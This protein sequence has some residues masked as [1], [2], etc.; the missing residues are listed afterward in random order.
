MIFILESNRYLKKYIKASLICKYLPRFLIT[1]LILT[2][3]FLFP[4]FSVI[5]N[6]LGAISGIIMQF[7]LPIVSYQIYF[8]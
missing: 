3:A 8:R 5:L 6:L 4:K 1:M 7:I 2:L